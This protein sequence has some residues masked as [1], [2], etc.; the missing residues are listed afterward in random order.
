MTENLLDNEITEFDQEEL[1]E[2]HRCDSNIDRRSFLQI[3]GAGLLITVT[4]ETAMGQRSR[5]RGGRSQPI[6]TRVHIDQNGRITVMTGKVEEGQGARAEIT[7]AAA[8]EL[9]VSAD[10]VTLVMA[11]TALVPDDGI[12]AGS[13]TTPY[14]IPAVRRGTAAARD[15]LMRLAAEQWKVDSKNLNVQQGTITNRKT[16]QTG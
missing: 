14:T 15:L 10:N 13:R 9:R 16:K 1:L 11:D 5:S 2:E 4:S 8:E 6:A 3:L 7:Q 12:T